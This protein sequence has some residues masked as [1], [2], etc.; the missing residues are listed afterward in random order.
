MTEMIDL[1]GDRRVHGC[2]FHFAQSMFRNLGKLTNAYLRGKIKEEVDDDV[3]VFRLVRCIMALPHLPLLW[4]RKRPSSAY[5][6][7]SRSRIDVQ[8]GMLTSSS[9][10]TS[11]DTTSKKVVRI[12]PA[13]GTSAGSTS[14]Q[15]T[16]PRVRTTF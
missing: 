5:E 1:V 10:T 9:M 13:F 12:R 6:M 8:Q 4:S 3:I 16:A 11:S 2:Y 14:E 15:T 7:R